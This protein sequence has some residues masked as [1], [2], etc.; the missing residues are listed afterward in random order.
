MK[1]KKLFQKLKLYS[2]NYQARC[3]PFGLR[4]SKG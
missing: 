3:S 4:V 2:L 1:L